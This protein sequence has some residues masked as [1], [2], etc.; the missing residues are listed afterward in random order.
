MPQYVA[1]DDGKCKSPDTCTR[2]LRAIERRANRQVRRLYEVTRGGWGRKAKA[3]AW[4]R[5]AE[6]RR[7]G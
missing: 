1:C 2:F 3:E 7:A 6:M 4:E 5:L